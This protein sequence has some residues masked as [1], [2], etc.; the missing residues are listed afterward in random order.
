MIWKVLSPK[1]D[2]QAAERATLSKL[3]SLLPH[4]LPINQAD[5]IEMLVKGLPPAEVVNRLGSAL[6]EQFARR[7]AFI[8][9]LQCN[10]SMQQSRFDFLNQEHER[11]LAAPLYQQRQAALEKLARTEN[12]LD[13]MINVAEYSQNALEQTRSELQAEQTARQEEV[14][15]LQDNIARQNRIISQQ[16]LRLNALLG[17]TPGAE[18]PG[19]KSK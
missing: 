4:S 2:Q 17:N 6:S 13:T 12:E 10:L 7:D 8:H 15:K 11:L 14:E 18:T 19:S 5:F 9:Q 16:Q 3:L 1:E